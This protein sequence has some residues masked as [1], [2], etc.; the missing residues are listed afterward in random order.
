[1]Y[2]ITKENNEWIVSHKGLI[3]AYFDADQKHMAQEYVECQKMDD[4]RQAVESAFNA[5]Q[6]TKALI[7]SFMEEF[8]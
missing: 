2:K 7:A 3:I 5:E 8:N 1:M 4:E 6:E